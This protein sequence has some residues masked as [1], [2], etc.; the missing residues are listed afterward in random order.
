M[1][2][3]EVPGAGRV[4]IVETGEDWPGVRERSRG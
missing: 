2:G 1:D 4:A 3:L